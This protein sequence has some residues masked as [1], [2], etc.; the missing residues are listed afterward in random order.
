MKDSQDDERSANDILEEN[1]Q[2]LW[3]LFYPEKPMR[4][5][6][7]DS[8][9]NNVTRLAASGDEQFILRIYNNYGNMDAVKLEHEMLDK[10]GTAVELPFHVPKPLSSLGGE[11][12]VKLSDGRAGAIFRYIEGER[13]SC[14][15]P[16][17]AEALGKAAGC[18]IKALTGILLEAKPQYSPY[19]EIASTY[20]SMSGSKLLAL[21]ET[22]PLL[23]EKKEALAVI[24][25]EREEIERVASELAELPRQWIHGDL[26]FNNSLHANNEIVGI[27]DFEFVTVDCRAMELAVLFVDMAKPW[28]PAAEDGVKAALKGFEAVVPLSTDEIRLLPAL[29]KLRLL[30][31]ALHFAIRYTEGLDGDKVFAGI[32][33]DTLYGIRW[34]REKTHLFG[35]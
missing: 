34:V 22:S 14:Q 21:A 13:P 4:L 5:I 17:H 32:V 6:E 8:G 31:V 25:R 16:Q 28:N 19:Y 33:D 7:G 27:L 29:M 30:D 10:L 15:S 11:T 20:A 9:M 24:Q 18:L 2:E 12:A 26:V 1:M 23:F 3:Q 35:I